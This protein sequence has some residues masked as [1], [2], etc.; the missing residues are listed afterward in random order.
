MTGAG[1]VMP[2]RLA[3]K[4]AVAWWGAFL[5]GLA[6]LVPVAGWFFVPSLTMLE[7]GT[8]AAF[9]LSGGWMLRR[10][11]VTQCRFRAGGC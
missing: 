9:V 7:I 11:V 4:F 3:G 1:R 10:L 8:L 6:S 2:E 5:A